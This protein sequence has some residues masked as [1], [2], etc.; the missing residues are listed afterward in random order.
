MKQAFTLIE[1]LVV[2]LIIGIL[3]AV[4]LP[5]YEVAVLKTKYANISLLAESYFKAAQA[6][7]LATGEWPGSFDI[8]DVSLPGGSAETTPRSGHCGL[9]KEY[10]CCLLTKDAGY[11]A[12]GISCGMQNERLGIQLNPDSNGNIS[13]RTCMAKTADKAA[14]QVCKSL[15]YLST[16]TYNLPGPNGHI[17]DITVYFY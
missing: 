4:A 11:Q 17:T 14:S 13:S 12:E 3:A 6:T 5:Q 15:G 9:F 16:T 1:L 2:V 7:R 10:Y 8:L